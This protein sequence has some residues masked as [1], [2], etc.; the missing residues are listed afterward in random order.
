MKHKITPPIHPFVIFTLSK[1]SADADKPPHHSSFS[2]EREAHRHQQNLYTTNLQR[3]STTFFI[4][5]TTFSHQPDLTL[6]YTSPLVNIT[7]IH[8][9]NHRDIE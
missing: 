2:E 9:Y 7:T 6:H 8:I 4:K 3:M 1:N 5:T